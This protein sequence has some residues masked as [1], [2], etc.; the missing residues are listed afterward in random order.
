MCGIWASILAKLSPELIR[1][2]SSKLARRGP[3]GTYS[4]KVKFK[5]TGEEINLVFHHL[6]L[7]GGTAYTHQPLMKDG[8]FLIC[9]GHIYNHREL[10][11]NTILLRH[12][13]RLGETLS[14]CEII[15]SLYCMIANRFNKEE[16]S[17]LL[18]LLD[19]VFAFVLVDTLR[20]RV[21]ISRDDFGVRP[22][23]ISKGQISGG[24][25][26]V[27]S[28]RKGILSESIPVYPGTSLL[29]ESGWETPREILWKPPR[30]G[31][32]L[33][34]TMTDSSRMMKIQ[35]AFKKAIHERLQV[36][37]A[38]GCLLSGGVM[39]TLMCKEV[40]DWFLLNRA[41]RG[42]SP[43]RIAKEVHTF[44]IGVGEENPDILFSRKVAEV[45][46][47]THHELIIKPEDLLRVGLHRE[48]VEGL[49]NDDLRLLKQAKPMW[50]LGK[51]IQEV[52]NTMRENKKGTIKKLFIG[53]GM[54]IILHPET[55]NTAFER[56]YLIF[57]RCFS[58]RGLDVE[59]PWLDNDVYQEILPGIKE[60]S[61]MFERMLERLTEF[62]EDVRKRNYIPM[63]M[64]LSSK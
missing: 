61:R 55:M 17:Q 46:G 8:V 52:S 36:K 44:T 13:L 6:A 59:F 14:D 5:A 28:L 7:Q 37:P 43:K 11:K 33:K 4:Q 9:N 21:L 20:N 56:E 48:V 60:G 53:E 51:F 22:L 40:V 3:D 39:S 15:L 30:V 19:G 27:S 32:P 34:S 47:T 12:G 41:G 63:E 45:L 58:I 35:E 49:E 23:Y 31:L 54:D 25:W 24:G 62:P 50:L 57:D 10:F 26:V 18:R 38:I 16:W 29:I 64:V 42:R 2:L 1:K